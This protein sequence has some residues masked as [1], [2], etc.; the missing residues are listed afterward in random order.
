MQKHCTNPV[1]VSDNIATFE[2]AIKNVRDWVVCEKDAPVTAYC[3]KQHCLLVKKYMLLPVK[4]MT[5][6]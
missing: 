2:T 1:E 4:C 5:L 3:R 6:F